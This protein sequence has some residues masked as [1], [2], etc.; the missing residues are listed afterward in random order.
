MGMVG[1]C[2]SYFRIKRARI[3]R[4]ANRISYLKTSREVI[5]PD[6]AVFKIPNVSY[7]QKVHQFEIEESVK[8]GEEVGILKGEHFGAVG[9]IDSLSGKMAVVRVVQPTCKTQDRI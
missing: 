4:V 1:T 3:V 8:K 6:F 7:I 5:V 9:T 2:A